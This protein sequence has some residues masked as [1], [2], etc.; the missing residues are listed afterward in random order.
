MDRKVLSVEIG[1]DHWR[2]L[3]R[4]RAERTDAAG[5]SVSLRSLI[6]EAIRLLAEAK[7]A[8]V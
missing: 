5:R 4:L 2:E 3:F 7:R 1:V 6:E 8:Q